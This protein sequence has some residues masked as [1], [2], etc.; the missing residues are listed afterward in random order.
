[1]YRNINSRYG[2]PISFSTLAQLENA[3][4]ECGYE[5]PEDGL[6]EGR[7][8]EIVTYL[9]NP[10]TGTVQSQDAWLS[11]FDNCEPEEWGGPEFG[12]AELLEVV[13]NIEGEEGYDAYFGEWRPAY[14][15][16]D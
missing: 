5:L 11:D 12:D 16:N 6:Q 9:M 13:P 2:D 14:P 15:L 4:R 3:I 10:Y 8:Y 7:D 1:M